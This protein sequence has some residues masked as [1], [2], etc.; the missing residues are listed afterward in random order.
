MG[1][2]PFDLWKPRLRAVIFDMDGVLVHSSGIHSR[3]FEEVLKPLGVPF[4]YSEYAGMRTRDVMERAVRAA[5]L[6]MGSAE[7]EHLSRRKSA[8]AL[9]RLT[10]ENPLAPRSREVLER[11]SA[12]YPLALATSASDSTVEAMM[13]GNLLLPYFRHIVSAAQCREAK[14][15]PEIYLRAA[16]LLDVD[17]SSCLVVEDAAAG[18]A[19]AK[20]AGAICA[21]I[22]GTLPYEALRMSDAD[23]VLT[24]ISE[25]L[26]LDT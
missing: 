7:L 8:A 20:A 14:P 21:A 13:G 6:V 19:A 1:V 11:L 5:G 10:Q 23:L 2:N 12:R 26:Q 24:D 4:D 15:S 22:A 9:R 17:P 18:I 25:L 16:Q 3:A